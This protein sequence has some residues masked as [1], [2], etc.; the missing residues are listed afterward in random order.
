MIVLA[1]VLGTIVYRISFMASVYG[2][3]SYFLKKHA[4][5]FTTMS[6][7]TINLIIIMILTRVKKPFT[8]YFSASPTVCFP[9]LP[10]SCHKTY[11]FR[12]SE[13]SH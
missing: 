8:Q 6:A 9:D 3:D 1:A 7:A 4:K 11:E 12:E 5:M 2:N 13:D 10:Q